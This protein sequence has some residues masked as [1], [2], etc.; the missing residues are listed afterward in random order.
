MVRQLLECK[1]LRISAEYIKM[2]G[3]QVFLKLYNAV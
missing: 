2:P 3:L 1:I